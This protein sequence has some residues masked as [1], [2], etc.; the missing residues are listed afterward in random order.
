MATSNNASNL[1]NEVLKH[2]HDLGLFELVKLKGTENETTIESV[3][4]DKS[5]ILMGK[6]NNHIP[7]FNEQVLGLSRMSIL[8][9]FMNYFNDKD[10]TKVSV[11]SEI[12][13]SKSVPTEANFKDK[14][15]T[16]ASYRFMLAAV[17]EQ[18]LKDI[19]FLGAKF[20]V[21]FVPTLKNIK[22][23]TQFNSILGAYDATVVPR[24]EDGNLY[25]YIGDGA[26]DRSRIMMSAGVKGELRHDYTWSIDTLLKVFKLI[27][28]ADAVVSINNNGLMQ[29]QVV[30][31]SGE[32]T[33]YFPAKG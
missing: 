3:S 15:G 25:F 8:R 1:F 21:N 10:N 4:S 11:V 24:I 6:V 30:S 9:G 29:V 2:T 28:S 23:L 5:V 14:N 7:E 33:Y 12:R 19:T 27:E 31:A 13:N 22:D 32:Y 17:V 20:D 18:Q 16:E 26:S